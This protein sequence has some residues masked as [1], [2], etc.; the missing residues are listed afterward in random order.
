MMGPRHSTNFQMNKQYSGGPENPTSG[1]ASTSAMANKSLGKRN[2]SQGGMK[3][4]KN[5]S[6]VPLP[7]QQSA[8]HHHRS[9]AN[10]QHRQASSG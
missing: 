6:N 8:P 4:A 10:S 1:S 5:S 2:T 9:G 3:E 7:K